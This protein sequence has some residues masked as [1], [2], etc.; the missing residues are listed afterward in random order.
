M[1]VISSVFFSRGKFKI[2]KINICIK[3]TQMF[4]K[5][6]LLEVGAFLSILYEQKGEFNLPK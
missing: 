2:S 4:S 1:S 5:N 6:T 3:K